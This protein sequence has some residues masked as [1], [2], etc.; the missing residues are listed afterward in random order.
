ME[1]LRL[2]FYEEFADQIDNDPHFDDVAAFA[3]WLRYNE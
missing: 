1:E 3:Q 2:R